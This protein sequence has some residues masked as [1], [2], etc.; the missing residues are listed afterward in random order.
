MIIGSNLGSFI[1]AHFGTPVVVD[2]QSGT[3]PTPLLFWAAAVATILCL[4]P[5]LFIKQDKQDK[6]DDEVLEEKS[7]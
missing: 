7:N 3:A 5:I 6:N 2:G 4:I 1:I